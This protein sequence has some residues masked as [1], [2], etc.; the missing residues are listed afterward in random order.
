MK[1]THVVLK[2][3]D[4]EKYCSD[5]QQE[6]LK[7][8]MDAVAAGRKADGKNPNAEY[9]V[10][11]MDEPYADQVLSLIRRCENPNEPTLQERIIRAWN[12]ANQ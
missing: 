11:N 2:R 10:C 5:Q 7:E 6:S 1:I 12:E 8:I 9:I 4:I 3:E